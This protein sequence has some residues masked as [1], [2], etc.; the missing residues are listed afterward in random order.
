VNVAEVLEG[1]KVCANSTE[2]TSELVPEDIVKIGGKAHLTT[3]SEQANRGGTVVECP[4]AGL[5][6][7]FGGPQRRLAR[8]EAIKLKQ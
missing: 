5:K 3:C 2:Y 4:Y 8:V 1:K 6:F 7:V